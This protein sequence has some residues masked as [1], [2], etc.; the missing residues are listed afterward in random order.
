[1]HGVCVRGMEDCYDNVLTPGKLPG[2]YCELV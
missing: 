2:L 1:M